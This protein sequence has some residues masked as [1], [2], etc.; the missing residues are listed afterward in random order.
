MPIKENKKMNFFS[1]LMDYQSLE[2]KN[3]NLTMFGV[4]YLITFNFIMS[5]DNGTKY[6]NNTAKGFLISII[7]LR[8]IPVMVCLVLM[9]IDV[10]K[11]NI[12]NTMPKAIVFSII[13]YVVLQLPLY[14]VL[15]NAPSAWLW[16]TLAFTAP[17]AYFFGA[18][19][20]RE[21]CGY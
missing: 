14:I 11:K 8:C 9:L 16:V 21:Y 18:L 17:Y 6:S 10:C 15:Y 12:R 4:I 1:R 20:L 3:D 13:C 5:F 2:R 7:L 19:Y